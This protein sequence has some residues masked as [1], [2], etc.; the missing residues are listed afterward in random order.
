MVARPYGVDEPCP[1]VRNVLPP[2][3]KCHLL[4]CPNDVVAPVMRYRDRRYAPHPP[5][6]VFPS[7]IARQP[8]VAPIPNDASS[9]SSRRDVSNVDGFMAPAIFR[10]LLWRYRPWEIG[11]GACGIIYPVVYGVRDRH[12]GISQHASR[13]LLQVAGTPPLCTIWA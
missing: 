11:P 6:A 4:L 13:T 3:P 5:G 9:K 8:R 10:L 12:L 7:S 1:A 2:P